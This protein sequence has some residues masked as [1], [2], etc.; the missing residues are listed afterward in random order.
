M[1]GLYLKSPSLDSYTYDHIANVTLDRML[2]KRVQCYKTHQTT[3]CFEMRVMQPKISSRRDTRHTL[4]NPPWSIR[5][6]LSQTNHSINV[7]LFDPPI[8]SSCSD[9]MLLWVIGIGFLRWGWSRGVGFPFHSSSRR[10]WADPNESKVVRPAADSASL[11]NELV[12]AVPIPAAAAQH[13]FFFGFQSR[14]LSVAG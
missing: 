4:Y 11:T 9:A 14:F 5:T 7:K 12:T 8:F 1:A 3:T 10:G 13:C 2:M 6:P